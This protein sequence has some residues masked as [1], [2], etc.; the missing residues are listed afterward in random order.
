[1]K[2]STGCIGVIAGTHS[3]K[4]G[5]NDVFTEG[6]LNAMYPNPGI[7]PNLGTSYNNN[8]HCYEPYEVFD[9]MAIYSVGEIMNE[10][11]IKLIKCYDFTFDDEI[12][13]NGHIQ[14]LSLFHLF[15][16]PSMEIYTGVA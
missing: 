13:K 7:V 9:T 16:D 4:S 8:I 1:M 3:T 10:G 14:T 11:F 5:Y 12:Q 15:G 2:G 6:M